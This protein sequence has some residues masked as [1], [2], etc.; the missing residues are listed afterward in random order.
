M[1]QHYLK[2]IA[3]FFVITSSHKVFP[4]LTTQLNQLQPLIKQYL[5]LKEQID[6][7]S[8]SNELA[9]L[10]AFASSPKITLLRLRDMI[11]DV[12]INKAILALTKT[13]ETITVSMLLQKIRTYNTG[14]KALLRITDDLMQDKRS[15]H[16]LIKNL[17]ELNSHKKQTLENFLNAF[18][19]IIQTRYQILQTINEY[20][21][22]R[23]AAFE[24][25]VE[26]R[27]FAGAQQF[28]MQPKK[29]DSSGQTPKKKGD[30]VLVLK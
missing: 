30:I 16:N 2:I 26:N 9:E 28:L 13:H 4:N 19:P 18:L 5:E 8:E 10:E 17:K 7:D 20:R 25:D 12:K 11:D 21:K 14:N 6:P 24:S 22:Q 15:V 29:Q 27:L 1:K 23:T 3:L